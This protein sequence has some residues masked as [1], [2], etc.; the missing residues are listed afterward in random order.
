MPYGEV[1][2]CQL[3]QEELLAAPLLV[4]QLA[5]LVLLQ[6]LIS[7][8]LPLLLLLMPMLQLLALDPTS[9]KA[10]GSHELWQHSL[11]MQ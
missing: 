10:R 7:L 4:A 8:L 9:L 11:Q 5:I 6:V 1:L 3:A 2:A